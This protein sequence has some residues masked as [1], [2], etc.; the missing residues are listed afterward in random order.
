MDL[1]WRNVL[2]V[3]CVWDPEDRRLGKALLTVAQA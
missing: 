1:Q 2:L 3:G